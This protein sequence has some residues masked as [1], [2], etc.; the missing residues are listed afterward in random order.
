VTCCLAHGGNRF[1]NIVGSMDQDAINGDKES[2]TDAAMPAGNVGGGCRRQ[3]VTEA[4]MNPNGVGD[5]V[6]GGGMV[7][8]R[9]RDRF[10]RRGTERVGGGLFILS[11]LL[12]SAAAVW[13]DGVVA[14]YVG[15]EVVG[16]LGAAYGPQR[17][18]VSGG[19]IGV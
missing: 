6:K 5:E 10:V 12:D 13:I 3:E 7:D 15:G 16:T 11:L 8:A 9:E 2:M 18:W 19:A 1:L 14:S 17:A 4:G